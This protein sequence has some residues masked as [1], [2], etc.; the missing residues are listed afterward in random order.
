M[1]ERNRIAT[2]SKERQRLSAGF[3]EAEAGERDATV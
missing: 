3:G 2:S 1:K